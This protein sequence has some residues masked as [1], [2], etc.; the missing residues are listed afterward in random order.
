MLAPVTSRWPCPCCGHL[1]LPDGP[2]A[3][4]LCTVCFWEDDG[5]QLRWPMSSNGANAI[6]LTEAQQRYQRIGAMDRAFRRKVRPPRATE[7]LDP[8]W[9]PFDP[10]VDWTH[11]E[12]AGERWPANSEALYYWRPTYWDGDPHR[13]PAPPREVTGGDRLVRHLL[14]EVPKI[15]AVVDAVEWQYGEADAMVVC[16]EAADAAVDAYREGKDRLGLGIARALAPG[17]DEASELYAPNCVSIGFLEND[18]WHDAALQPFIDQWPEALRAEIREQQAHVARSRARTAAWPELWK[19]SRGQPIHAIEEQ[20][21]DLDGVHGGG[22][23]VD[24]HRA[25][26]ARVMSDHRWGYRH[27]LAALALA[28]RYRSV[29]SPLRTL[30]WLRRPRFAG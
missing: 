23:T 22:A 16:T 27:P 14:D 4:E 5:S 9:R 12:L 20:A 21:R 29:Q 19:S 1:T 6:S 26:M 13:T 25:L 24:L 2:G 3:Y 7:S 10:D 11:P 17:L 8:G 28:W 30:N 18:A 15:R